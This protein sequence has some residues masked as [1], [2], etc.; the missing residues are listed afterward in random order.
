MTL[1]RLL[2]ETQQWERLI[3]T[4]STVLR[5]HPD[6]CEALYMRGW[7]FL[8]NGDKETAQTHFKKVR[9]MEVIDG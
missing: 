9:T 8:M 1:G 7:G 5:S 6:D 3:Q 2:L 4:C